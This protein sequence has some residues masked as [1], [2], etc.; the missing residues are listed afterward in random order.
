MRS[1]SEGIM[2]DAEIEA[3]AARHLFNVVPART[4]LWS[5]SLRSVSSARR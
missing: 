2:G 5:N 3:E 1:L 4:P